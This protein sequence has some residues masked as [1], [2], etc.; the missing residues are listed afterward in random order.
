MAS[1]NRVYTANEVVRLLNNADYASFDSDS[2]LESSSDESDSDSVDNIESES[3]S[4]S[5][6][7]ATI[8][9]DVVD[10][11]T[12]SSSP[13]S[14][15]RRLDFT[16]NAGLHVILQDPTDPLE[17]F[18]SFVTTEILEPVVDETN[19]RAAQLLA[20]P[21]LKG[22]S[23]LRQWF[24]TTMN[25]LKSFIALSL[26]MGVIW[27][28]KLK[29]YWTTKPMLETPHV[30]RLMTEKRFSL[31]MKCLHFVNSDLIVAGASKAEKSFSKIT[32][33]FDALIHQFQSVYTPSA[34][35]AIDESLMLWKGRLAMKQYIP[36][37]RARFGLKSYELCESG[38]GYTW[39][40]IIHTGP[41]MQLEHSSD[42]LK[43]LL[44]QGY[45]FY[46]DTWYSSPALFRQLRQ[47]DTDAVGTVRLSRSRMP[48]DLKPKIPHGTITARYSKNLMALK[49]H[50]K[51]EIMML[52]TFHVSDTQSVKSRQGD[53]NK[54]V[55]IIDYN[56]NMGAV[57]MADQMLQSYQVER[58]RKKVWY[59]KQ[60]Q[61]LLNQTVLNCYILYK[62]QN[63]GSK[64]THL[65]FVVK[66]IARLIEQYGSETPPARR[67]RPS[68]DAV[69]DPPS[70][71]TSFPEGDPAD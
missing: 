27:K 32:P 38:S 8:I 64:T 44:D 68:K 61:H 40:S 67:G 45:C 39:N 69:V 53:K 29:M 42:G 34:N 36:L 21:G 43:Q 14:N 4:D 65:N 26:Y 1:R 62:K 7:D 60:F 23:R 55:V 10:D 66:L 59:K 11:V 37:K 17:Y 3:G 63:P 28:P 41:M 54:P 16:G 57:D 48:P 35:V 9:V 56:R 15:M 25:E 20:K 50:D 24:D 70:V 71:R 6:S 47:R 13:V 51:R 18:E 31:L 19:R 2:V 33:F 30:R 49:W 12:W 58:K 46:M 22:G 5:D 52:S